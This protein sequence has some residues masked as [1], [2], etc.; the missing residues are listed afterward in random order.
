[1]IAMHRSRSSVATLCL[2]TLIGCSDA[3]GSKS[4]PVTDD[5]TDSDDAQP[6]RTYRLGGRAEA[7]GPTLGSPESF[8]HLGKLPNLAEFGEAENCYNKQ[9]AIDNTI[10]IPIGNK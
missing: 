7:I 5:A 2:L 8:R 1:M 4:D 9:M 3:G 6:L 10:M